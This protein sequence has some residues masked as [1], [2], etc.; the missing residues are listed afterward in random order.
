MIRKILLGLMTS[1]L[2][3]GCGTN[4]DKKY[5]ITNEQIEK[6]NLQ[7]D[8][9][10]LQ[11]I[12]DVY[13]KNMENAKTDDEKCVVVLKYA[14]D[15]FQLTCN[16]YNLDYDILSVF[17][18]EYLDYVAACRV[19]STTYVGERNQLIDDK[20]IGNEDYMKMNT[21][22]G[23]MLTELERLLNGFSNQYHF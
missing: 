18:E 1:L 16:R 3:V 2:L 14:D 6:A 13:E 17:S 20:K 8:Y 11:D 4:I 22:T 19:Y 5:E 7:E 23:I 21:E 15:V 9:L 12:Q 10:L